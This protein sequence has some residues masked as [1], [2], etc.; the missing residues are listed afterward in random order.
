MAP[1]VNFGCHKVI[2]S[3][4]GLKHLTESFVMIGSTLWLLDSSDMA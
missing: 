1:E 2:K 3:L 4:V